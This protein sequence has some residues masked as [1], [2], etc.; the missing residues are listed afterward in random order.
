MGVTWTSVNRFEKQMQWVHRN[1]WRTVDLQNEKFENINFEFF[2]VFDDG[3]ECIHEFAFP[4]LEK[5]EFKAFLYIPTAYINKYNTWDYHMIGPRFKHLNLTQLRELSEKGWVIGSHTATHRSLTDMSEKEIIHELDTSKKTLEDKLG[6]EIVWVSF[7]FGR[8]NELVLDIAVNLGYKF[9][10]VPVMK[11]INIPDGFK[12][13]QSDAVYLWDSQKSVQ[14]CLNQNNAYIVQRRFKRFAN[15]LSGGTIL[16]K[17]LL[18][19][20]K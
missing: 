6:K 7:P 18:N 1:G 15:R 8:Y 3:Y 5:L 14:S 9:G 4:I 16:L 11:E 13:I 19:A 17:K 2:L 12:L 20:R 10:V